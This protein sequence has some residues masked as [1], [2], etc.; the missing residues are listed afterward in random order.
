MMPRYRFHIYNDEETMDHQGRLFPDLAAAR[1]EAIVSARD[2]MATD[3]RAKGEINL[4]HWIELE[5]DDGEVEVVNF[6]DAVT[7]KP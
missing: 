4:S 6:R 2:L 3:I 5:D 7:I 1:T